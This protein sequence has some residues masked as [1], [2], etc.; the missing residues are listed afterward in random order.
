MCARGAFKF[1]HLSVE[2]R[3]TRAAACAGVARGVV[4]AHAGVD[5]V[6]PEASS[7][8][9][10]R[11]VL[12]HE[13][14]VALAFARHGVAVAVDTLAFLLAVVP[15]HTRRAR[16][17]AELSCETWRTFALSRPFIASSTVL[18]LTYSCAVLSI[19]T[20]WTPLAAGWADVAVRANASA[21]ADI[22]C[23][24]I[25]TLTD[26]VTIWTILSVS[27]PCIQLLQ[28]LCLEGLSS[29]VPAFSFPTLPK[30]FPFPSGFSVAVL[31][32]EARLAH[33]LPGDRV[34]DGVCVARTLA[35]ALRPE[36]T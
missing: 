32:L 20:F 11:A 14:Q 7:G 28:S 17:L 1:A 2:S 35:P 36:G 19:A 15:E 9:A 31:S 33:A 29:F 26:A 5:A 10:L 34:A 25:L 30:L 22:A 12:S 4:L 16:V 24:V 3:T 18:A 8:A 23:A 6:W 13:A 27:A 21:R